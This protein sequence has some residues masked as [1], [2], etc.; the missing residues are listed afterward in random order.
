MSS[1]SRAVFHSKSSPPGCTA[2]PGPGRALSASTRKVGKLRARSCLGKTGPVEMGS[3]QKLTRP[4]GRKTGPE[5]T[6]D[7]EG[8]VL[9]SSSA[10]A[11]TLALLTD[12]QGEG[13]AQAR[14]NSQKNFLRK[15][16]SPQVQAY[17]HGKRRTP[18]AI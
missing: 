4:C 6:G 16:Q 11:Q 12:D 18:D 10:L 1:A 14:F 17:T 9:V 5:K 7:A 15:L 8:Q 3:F 13:P 2:A